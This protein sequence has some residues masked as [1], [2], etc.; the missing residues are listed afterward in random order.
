VTPPRPRTRSPWPLLL[1]LVSL[2]ARASG[3]PGVSPPTTGQPRAHHAGPRSPEECLSSFTTATRHLVARQPFE[4]AQIFYG[5]GLVCTHL[6]EVWV[7]LAFTEV[8]TRHP[9]LSKQK[10]SLLETLPEARAWAHE[11]QAAVA[12]ASG[13][14]AE[15]GR[16]YRELLRL[17]PDDPHL[18]MALAVIEA[19][20]GRPAEGRK[21][22]LRL[23]R[24]GRDVR[25]DE[26]VVFPVEE[27]AL[28]LHEEVAIREG[29][30]PEARAA[31]RA[32][33]LKDWAARLDVSSAAALRV[34]AL[35]LVDEALRVAPDR[36]DLWLDRLDLVSA[37][38]GDGGP[39]CE[40]MAK[41]V[42]DLVEVARCRGRLAWVRRDLG[43]ACEH[44]GYV[45]RYRPQDGEGRVGEVAC[46]WWRDGVLPREPPGRSR[47]APPAAPLT[48][49]L[50]GRGLLEA[51]RTEEGGEWFRARARDAP[52]DLSVLGELARALQR[53][54]R[55]TAEALR[56]HIAE[57]ARADERSRTDRTLVAR[58]WRVL[59]AAGRALAAGDLAA[60]E[61]HFA[62][63]VRPADLDVAGL[64]GL[65]R[66]AVAR[67]DGAA[68]RRFADLLLVRARE[69]NREFFGGLL[70]EWRKQQKKAEERKARQGKPPDED[71]A[72]AS[73]KRLLGVPDE[74]PRTG[75]M[76]PPE[77]RPA[78]PVAV[79]GMGEARAPAA[80]PPSPP[81]DDYGFDFG[82]VSKEKPTWEPR[83]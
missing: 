56:R 17:T 15:A 19:V 78:Q 68:Q 39:V 57:T 26:F 11:L 12:A 64:Y 38:S 21:P 63:G 82:S 46:R 37:L 51:G 83:R 20:A 72:R 18:L 22:L 61:R 48:V 59:R 34:E 70:E 49:V 35:G 55:Q 7:G 47:R 27:L 29:A 79:E 25:P 65:L 81:K 67:N 32:S 33:L 58:R 43:G 80:S 5:A 71:P 36:P 62:A 13:E 50:Y 31:V 4:A 75:S 3:P 24:L 42:K 10:L 14:V 60:A 45:R 53:D 6:P 8:L 23:A 40:A 76:P 30:S 73:V 44:W 52:G 16:R 28:R 69:A 41:A 66:V 54:D 2:P 77:P 74:P 1:V 9:E